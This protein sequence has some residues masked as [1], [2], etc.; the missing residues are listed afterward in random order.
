M[1]TESGLR[2]IIC[3]P[4]NT[5]EV[6]KQMGYSSYKR[7]KAFKVLLMLKRYLPENIEDVNFGEVD[8]NL[9]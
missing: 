3:D 4:D 2:E 8:G 9:A 1:L 5:C 7:R 6:L